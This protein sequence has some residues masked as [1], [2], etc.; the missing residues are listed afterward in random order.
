MELILH[1]NN[2][3]SYHST[4]IFRHNFKIEKW[5]GKNPSI[6]AAFASKNG[7]EVHSLR[8][9]IGEMIEKSPQAVPFNNSGVYDIS[10]DVE[11]LISKW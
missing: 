11:S 9:L 4:N 3:Q 7:T 8:R 1:P 5:V 10:S 6:I 2:S